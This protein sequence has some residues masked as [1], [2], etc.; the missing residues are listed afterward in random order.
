ME[1]QETEVWSL[2]WE[3]PLEEAMAIQSSIFA[4]KSLWTE[5]PR[6]RGTVHGIS[7]RYWHYW[8]HL[9]P[10]TQHTHI[11]K[12]S[13]LMLSNS[14]A[15]F[16][17]PSP[18]PHIHTFGLLPSIQD[19]PQHPAGAFLSLDH[20][21]CHSLNL[22]TLPPAFHKLL[23]SLYSGQ[24]RCHLLPKSSWFA[25]LSPVPLWTE[26]PVRVGILVTSIPEP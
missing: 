25:L 24:L 2:G 17:P 22:N 7:Q 21:S 14:K 8:S 23:S 10:S 9:S 15:W 11:N 1:T 19:W 18:L 6:E 3:D 26:S 5:E 16:L 12:W 20:C 4:W 13:H